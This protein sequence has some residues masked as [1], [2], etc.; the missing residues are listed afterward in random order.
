MPML[1]HVGRA[2]NIVAWVIV[3]G[4]LV[5]CIAVS[6]AHGKGRV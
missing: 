1:H 6:W 2:M 4:A 5:L 3:I